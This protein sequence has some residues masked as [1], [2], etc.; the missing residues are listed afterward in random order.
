MFCTHISLNIVAVTPINTILHIYINKHGSTYFS[1]ENTPTPGR[2]E[3]TV[4]HICMIHMSLSQQHLHHW[5][6]GSRCTVISHITT[7]S[8]THTCLYLTQ[9]LTHVSLNKVVN[10]LG[11]TKHRVSLKNTANKQPNVTKQTTLT[12]HNGTHNRHLK[13]QCLRPISLNTSFHTQATTDTMS[14]ILKHSNE[15]TWTSRVSHT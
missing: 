6:K 14:H 8:A 4:S 3:Y 11:K 10:T 7:H 1:K 13:L 15:K 12:A 9:Y 5:A 2:A